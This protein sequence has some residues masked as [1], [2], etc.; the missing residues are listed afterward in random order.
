[1]SCS[2]DMHALSLFH[3]YSGGLI[4][5][6]IARQISVVGFWLLAI[7]SYLIII[8]SRFHYTIDVFMAIFVTTT[9]FKLY[10]YFIKMNRFAFLSWYEAEETI[11]AIDPKTEENQPLI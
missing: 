8:A 3:E 4:S 1:M 2:Q 5:N 11:E 10:H 7:T 6:E 9:V